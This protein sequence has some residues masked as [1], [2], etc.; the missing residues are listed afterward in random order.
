M[1][2]IVGTAHKVEHLPSRICESELPTTS[3]CSQLKRSVQPAIHQNLFRDS[4]NRPKDDIKAIKGTL[5]SSLAMLQD[6]LF[7][8]YNAIVRASPASREGM[9]DFFGMVVKRNVKRSGMQVGHPGCS[10][11]ESLG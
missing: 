8:V 1:V 9:L 3:P 10:Q 4:E 2:L 5:G 11:A 6:A 7:N